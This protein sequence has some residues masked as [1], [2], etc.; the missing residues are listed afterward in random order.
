LSQIRPKKFLRTQKEHKIIKLTVG[1]GRSITISPQRTGFDH[2]F[3]EFCRLIRKKSAGH[4]SAWKSK[5]RS[6]NP[7]KIILPHIN[8]GRVNQGEKFKKKLKSINK[9]LCRSA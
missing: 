8:L 7:K 5:I 1:K 6:P 2:D 9:L 4:G 3:L